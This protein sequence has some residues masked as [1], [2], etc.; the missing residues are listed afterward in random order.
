MLNY[1][2]LKRKYNELLTKYDIADDLPTILERRSWLVSENQVLSE[3]LDKKKALLREYQSLE[4]LSREVSSKREEIALLEEKIEKLKSVLG[5]LESIDQIRRE[6]EFLEERKKILQG[7]NVK[8]YDPSKIIYA[9]YGALSF[10]EDDNFSFDLAV[11][12]YQGE[13]KYTNDDDE[14]HKCKEFQSI[15]GS[16]WAAYSGY[17]DEIFESEN[18]SYNACLGSW[19]TFEEVCIAMGSKLYL[20]KEVTYEEI[21]EVMSIFDNYNINEVDIVEII[22]ELANNQKKERK[23]KR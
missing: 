20:E 12:I 10:D 3:N 2:N 8:K 5:N 6:I 18:R 22:R 17:D 16:N 13:A 19:I 23:R 21:M 15:G 9:T 7:K 11:F 14:T 1:F 4:E